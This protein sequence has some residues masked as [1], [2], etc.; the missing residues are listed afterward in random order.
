[1]RMKGT[2]AMTKFGTELLQSLGDAL[3]HAKGEDVG[4]KKRH[5]YVN[6]TITL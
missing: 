2:A 3:A 4:E 6:K 1:M 5:L